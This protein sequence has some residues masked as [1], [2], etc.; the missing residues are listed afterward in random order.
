MHYLEPATAP[1]ALFEPEA[2]AA[3][4]WPGRDFEPSSAGSL[5]GDLREVDFLIR[6]QEH[7]YAR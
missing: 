5:R 4:T 2:D 3:S 6:T 1:T 7:A